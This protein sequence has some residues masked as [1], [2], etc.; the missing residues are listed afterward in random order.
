M[1]GIC[2]PSG[3][4]SQDIT[5]TALQRPVCFGEIGESIGVLRNAPAQKIDIHDMASGA[6]RCGRDIVYRECVS[7]TDTK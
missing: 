7:G 2:K 3:K 4:Y 5:C 6:C 1:V